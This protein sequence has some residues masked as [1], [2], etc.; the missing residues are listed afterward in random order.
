MKREVNIEN[1]NRKAH[2]LF[3]SQFDEPFFGITLTVACTEAYH[4]SKRNGWSFFLVY[5]YKALRAANEAE[6]FRYRI[7]DGKVFI[8]DEINVATTI[9]RPD[10][11]FGFA[12]LDYD[13][14]ETVFYEKAHDIIDQVKQSTGLRLAEPGENTIHFSALPWLNFTSMS[15]ARN[16][17]FPDSSPK[18]S[19]GKVTEL[20]GVKTMPVSIHVHHG[21]VDGYHVGLFADRFQELMNASFDDTIDT[22]LPI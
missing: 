14:S 19:F 6:A 5:L 12:Y 18:I 7:I 13:K 21:L 4:Y 22:E 8:L 16:Y 1:W 20:N 10:G 9:G 15:H 3:F 11:T 17:S 2:Y